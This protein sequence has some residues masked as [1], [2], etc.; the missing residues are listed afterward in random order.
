MD[1]Q[2][3]MQTAVTRVP[4]HTTGRT[5]YQMMTRRDARMRHLPV[6]TAQ[7]TLIG[8]VT[9]RDIRRTLASDGSSPHHFRG[10]L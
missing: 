2:D 7:G 9:D 6:V 5:A 10:S 8:I 4:P 1:V 3:V